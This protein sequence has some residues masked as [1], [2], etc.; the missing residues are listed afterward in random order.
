MKNASPEENESASATETVTEK[1]DSE[2]ELSRQ[3]RSALIAF[4]G[5]SRSSKPQW[6]QELSA[7]VREIQERKAREGNAAPTPRV[8]FAAET[9]SGTKLGVVAPAEPQDVNPIVVA[10]LKRLERA[11]Q[12]SAQA[13]RTVLGRTGATA[14]ARLARE[15]LEFAAPIVAPAGG[16]EELEEPEA[17]PIKER[18][19]VVVPAA[20]VA[21]PPEAPESAPKPQPRKVIDGVVDD[22]YLARLEKELLPPVATYEPLEHYAPL[23]RRL[24]AAIFDLFV[25]GFAVTPFAAIIEL[26]DGNWGDLRVQAT[27]GGIVLLAMLIYQTASIGLSGRTF[28]MSIFSLRA[29]DSRTGVHPSTMQAIARAISYLLVMATGFIGVLTALFDGERRTIHDML[30]RTVL[31]SEG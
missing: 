9:R 4:P 12:G 15:E 24:G 1:S 13:A 6:R 19:L 7:R 29:V 3:T 8:E 2:G 16:V 22:A 27:M 26:R 14:T 11:R 25:M 20:Q 31:V 17:P 23:G 21:S 30:S 5:T 10:A 28:G 18:K